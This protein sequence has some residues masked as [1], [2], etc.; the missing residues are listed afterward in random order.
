MVSTIPPPHVHTQHTKCE[1]VQGSGWVRDH[2]RVGG[3]VHNDLEMI[4]QG[5]SKS[6][7][8]NSPQCPVQTTWAVN[9]QLNK[10]YV[11]LSNTVEEQTQKGLLKCDVPCSLPILILHII[12]IWR[13]CASVVTGKR[14]AVL[15]TQSVTIQ[16]TLINKHRQWFCYCLFKHNPQAI[17]DYS[18]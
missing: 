10:A 11:L 5:I 1:G 17:S 4:K 3:G 12:R 16:N 18:V 15:S 14:S 6:G 2:P 7:M 13:L 9:N 8:E